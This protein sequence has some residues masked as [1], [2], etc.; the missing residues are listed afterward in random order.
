MLSRW[1]LLHLQLLAPTNP[2]WARVVGYGPFSLCVINM[3][4]MNM[5]MMMG[6]IW[7]TTYSLFIFDPRK[8]KDESLHQCVL[9]VMTYGAETWTLTAQL[10]YKFKVAQRAMESNPKRGDPAEN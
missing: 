7:E 4:I 9:P 5:M 6:S 2:Q 8:P 10:V 3:L 1:C